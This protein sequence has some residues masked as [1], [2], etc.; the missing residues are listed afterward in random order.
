MSSMVAN[1]ERDYEVLMPAR[2]L[3]MNASTAP[4][5]SAW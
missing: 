2:G 5:T 1:K 4:L 3:S